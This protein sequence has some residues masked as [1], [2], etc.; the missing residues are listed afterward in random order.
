MYFWREGTLIKLAGK[1]ADKK[2]RRAS[3]SKAVLQAPNVERIFLCSL[4]WLQ[5]NARVALNAVLFFFLSP[6]SSARLKSR[7]RGPET[8]GGRR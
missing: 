6:F 2:A 5:Y 7:N 1:E 3:T 8:V 4:V